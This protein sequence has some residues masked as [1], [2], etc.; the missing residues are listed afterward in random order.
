MKPAALGLALAVTFA[1]SLWA[2]S[3]APARSFD[4]ADV[5][6]AG[7]SPIATGARNGS[8][9]DGVFRLRQATMVDLIRVAYGVDADKV[10]GGPSWLELDRFDVAAK[11]PPGTNREMVRPMLQALLADRF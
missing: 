4:V 10:T 5:H 2:Q 3:S 7:R 11:V 9:R 6:A 8:L 1:V